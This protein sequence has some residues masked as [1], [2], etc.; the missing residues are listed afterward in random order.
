MKKPI[1]ATIDGDLADW[2]EKE[3]ANNKNYRNKSHLIES[4]LEILKKVK[5]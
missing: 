2:I 1:S 5:K 3:V 4:A